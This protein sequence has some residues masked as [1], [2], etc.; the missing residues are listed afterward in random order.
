MIITQICC[1]H[2]YGDVDYDRE[3]WYL[4]VHSRFTAKIWSNKLWSV[5]GHMDRMPNGNVVLYLFGNFRI[6]ELSACLLVPSYGLNFINK[7]CVRYS[8]GLL[9][10]SVNTT[11]SCN[12]SAYDMH[13][14]LGIISSRY[15]NNLW[16]MSAS[17]GKG[18][19]WPTST[20]RV[21]TSQTFI[22]PEQDAYINATLNM[23]TGREENVS[24]DSFPWHGV[25]RA[26]QAIHPT[27]CCERL[28]AT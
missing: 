15:I 3:N 22:S 26:M 1:A 5:I 2:Y 18:F 7:R 27:A 24:H 14:V 9:W 13:L 4:F 23:L 11:Y 8:E 28:W 19:D 17:V 21:N 12:N 20:L 10:E 6:E 25:S 16:A